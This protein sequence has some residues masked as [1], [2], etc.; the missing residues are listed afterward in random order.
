MRKLAPA[1]SVI[2][3]MAAVPSPGLAGPWDFN[4]ENEA[5]YTVY[6]GC[7]VS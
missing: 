7:G 2:K 1:I 5:S 3:G 4:V 6:Y